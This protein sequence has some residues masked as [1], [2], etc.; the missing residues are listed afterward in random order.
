M[1]GLST[2]STAGTTTQ[3][4]QLL[5]IRVIYASTTI[6]AATKIAGT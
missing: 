4:R 5:P 6:S 3:T 2:S 1:L